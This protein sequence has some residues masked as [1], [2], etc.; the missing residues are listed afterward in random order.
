LINWLVDWLIVI[1]WLIVLID[2]LID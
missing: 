2:G 1:S